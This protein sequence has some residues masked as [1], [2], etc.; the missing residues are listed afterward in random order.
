MVLSYGCCR[1]ALFV[2]R[3][4]AKRGSS[5]GTQDAVRERRQRC[6]VLCLASGCPS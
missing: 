1:V 2:P 6:L 4:L 3:A 5:E